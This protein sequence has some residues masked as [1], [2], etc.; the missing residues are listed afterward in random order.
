MLQFLD[1]KLEFVQ[2]ETEDSV[3]AGELLT[4]LAFLAKHDDS[5]ELVH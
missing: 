5:F 1:I 4:I 2:L 3:R